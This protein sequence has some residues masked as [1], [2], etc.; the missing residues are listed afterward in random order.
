MSRLFVVALV[1]VAAYFAVRT[2]APQTIGETARRQFLALLQKHYAGKS[3]SIRRGHFDADVGLIFEDI[4]ISDASQSSFQFRQREMVR[5]ERLTV[6]GDVD[7]EKLLN[8]QTPLN[9]R[10][11]V[12]DG[13]QVNVWLDSAGEL[14]I[15]SLLPMPSFGPAAPRIDLRRVSVRLSDD[16]SRKRPIDAEFSQISLV[17]TPAGLVASPG[18]S[19]SM[20]EQT[21]TVRGNTDFASDLLIQIETKNGNT[22]IRGVVKGTHVGQELF[23]R[24]P[25]AWA[26]HTLHVQHLQC[27]SDVSFSVFKPAKGALNYLVKTRVNEGRFMHPNL[28]QPVSQI[29]GV[30][31]CRP[32]GLT[33][34]SSQ[35]SFGD[36]I[37]RVD[38]EVHGYGWPCEVELNVSA[39]NLLIDEQLAAR[40]PSTAQAQWGKLQPIGRVDIDT[41]LKH[42]N[43]VWNT[44][45]TLVCK[46]VDIRYE[47]FPY[48]VNALVGRV[49]IRDGI[50]TAEALDGRIGDNRMQCAFRVP[51]QPGIT[52]AKS[53]VIAS[54]GPVPVDNTLLTSLSPRGSEETGLERFVRS[55]RPRGS[56]ALATAK[57][58]TDAEGRKSRKMD[59]RVVNGHLRYEKFAYPLYNVA[60]KILIE[61]DLITLDGFRATN[62]NEGVVNCSGTYEL[63]RVTQPQQASRYQIS[64]K[65]IADDSLSRLK[66]NFKATNVPMDEALR[67][68]L[69]ESTKQ[70]WDS[71]AP[72]GVLDELQVRLEQYGLGNPLQL[73]ITANQVD[74]EQ[75]TSQTLSLRPPAIPYRLDIVG[76]TVGFDGSKVEINSIRARHD[77]STLSADGGCVQDASGRWELLLDLHNGSRLHPDRELIDA[78]PTQMREAM[79]R[80]QLRNPVS[81]SGNTRFALPDASHDEPDINWDL[82]LQLEG[83]RIADVGP[84]HSIR[85]EVN[86]K[87]VRDEL[88]PRAVGDVWIDSMHVYDLQVTGVRGPFSVDG[89]RLSLGSVSVNR[90]I[91]GDSGTTKQRA[92]RGKIFDGDIELDGD[93][94]LSSGQFDVG[95]VLR[96]GQVPTLLADFGT[97][98]AELKGTFSG[99]TNLQGNLGTTDLLKGSGAARVTGANLYKLPFIVKVLNLIRVTPTEDVAF[100]DAKIDY[101]LFGDTVTFSELEVWGDL[102]QLHGGGTLDRRRELDLSFNTRVSPQ[103]TFSKVIRPLRSPRYTLWTIDV[104][105]PMHAPEI[106]RRA[107]DGVGQTLERLFPGMVNDDSESE[108]K[109]SRFGNWMR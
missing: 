52:N 42:T 109:A 54:D 12:L 72:S 43:Q 103:S 46:G 30:F 23:S 19:S 32:E 33:I 13:V 39:R 105:G 84:V 49:E 69:P 75:V 78:L 65:V 44:N 4:R 77:A 107:L 22:D 53:F 106:E 100:T 60:G 38:G 87:G 18:E 34:E 11:I 104:T 91:D 27:Q 85:G 36:A 66:L 24:L 21:I 58:V 56:V 20:P 8:K 79:R 29:S 83:N 45:G 74:R 17:N 14:P 57:F 2:L 71:I 102:V 98:D 61:D 6:V 28:P 48:P 94:V 50:A 55:L 81:V 67:K 62:A 76:G 59:L 86:V 90:K 31:A 93:V 64:D 89:D 37:V 3:V 96:N 101:T 63:A 41:K 35:C 95:I 82:K 73:N 68:S 40:L 15:K 99:R 9:T 10:Q 25:A 97:S 26:K 5:I 7:V 1:I 108:Q 51:I 80:L 88:G 70:V 47:K 92:I 16:A